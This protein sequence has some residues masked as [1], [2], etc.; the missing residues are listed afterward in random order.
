MSSYYNKNN[1][2]VKYGSK[3][4]LI[5]KYYIEHFKNELFINFNSDD[6]YDL[7]S[8]KF[9]YEI[10]TDSNYIKYNKSVFV[11]FESNKKPS[12]IETSKA[13]YY[14]FVCP[15]NDNFDVIRIFEIETNILKELI[16]NNKFMYKNAPCKD[17]YNNIYSINTGY[18]IKESYLI[19]YGCSYEI[20]L[21][22]NEQ[23][24]SLVL[25]R[26]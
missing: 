20:I 2:F 26:A 6:K 25:E 10:K 5:A 19:K 13:N 11:E 12:G 7:M 18:I 21:N 3:G 9:K 15:N 17:Y 24:A 8:D 22:D 23:L 14:I 1:R 4:E 16:T